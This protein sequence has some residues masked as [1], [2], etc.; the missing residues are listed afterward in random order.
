MI[1][2][3]LLLALGIVG[4]LYAYERQKARPLHHDPCLH[5]QGLSGRDTWFPADPNLFRDRYGRAIEWHYGGCAWYLAE[6]PK[7]GHECKPQ[8][9][10]ITD[11][12]QHYDRC[13][14]GGTRFGVYGQWEM[15]NSRA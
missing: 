15:R 8:T 4:M 1:T 10:G 9:C 5:E 12:L 2:G 7:A 13:A 11:T 14:C 6:Q 3:G